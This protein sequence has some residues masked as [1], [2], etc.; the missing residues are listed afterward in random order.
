VRQLRNPTPVIHLDQD[1]LG[2]STLDHNFSVKW[3]NVSRLRIDIYDRL[4]CLTIGLKSEEALFAA[5]HS[6]L[7]GLEVRRNKMIFKAPIVLIASSEFSECPDVNLNKLF[8]F[9]E[10]QVSAIDPISAESEGVWP[11]APTV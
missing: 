10:R 6:C 2:I 8:S 7:L 4:T 5:K 1:R 3:D 11:P 9:M